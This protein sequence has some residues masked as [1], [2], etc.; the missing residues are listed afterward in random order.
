VP[1]N[2]SQE[3]I[4]LFSP[5]IT[6]IKTPVLRRNS[7]RWWIDKI[8]E[9][10]INVNILLDELLLKHEIDIVSHSSYI[11]KKVKT[12][13]WIMDFQHI[14]LP[15]LW[16]KRELEATRAFLHRLI[17]KGNGIFL[18]SYSAFEDFKVEYKS[19]INKVNILHF[20]SQPVNAL[21][22]KLSEIE[23]IELREKYS[24]AQPYFYLPNQ[25][26]SHKNHKIVFDAIKILKD[27][28]Y[29]P[30]LV[31]SGLMNDFRSK[32]DHIQQLKDFVFQNKL[33][34]NIFFLGLIPYKDVL[35]LV[36]GS[37]AV[38]NPSYFEGWSST[39]EEAKTMGKRL[40]LSDIKV[41]HEQGPSHGLFFDPDDSVML[42]SILEGIIIKEIEIIDLSIESLQEDLNKRTTQFSIDFLTGIKRV[43]ANN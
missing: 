2:L 1:D 6:I 33:E 31:T 8:F 17:V 10:S 41:H 7:F 26:W 16:T 38:I 21:K 35:S 30:L 34:E 32:A 23:E 27:K 29:S 9:K 12:I 14:N 25:F 18:S 20:V 42:A 24:I 4:D 40:I 36:T 5:Y 28:G 19:L 15:H 3:Y 11:S 22:L 43:L 13:N 37:E 39:V